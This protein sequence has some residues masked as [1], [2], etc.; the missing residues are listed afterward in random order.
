MKHFLTILMMII[1]MLNSSSEGQSIWTKD[2]ANPVLT[3]IRSTWN[4]NVELPSVLYNSDSARYEMWFCGDQGIMGQYYWRPYHIGYAV[5]DDG[6]HWDMHDTP[7]LDITA[8]KWDDL[9]VE[10]PTVIHEN[11]LYKMWYSGWNMADDSIGIGYATSADGMTWTKHPSY[12]FGPG[13]ADWESGYPYSCSVM[14][15][16]GGYEMWYSATDITQSEFNIGYATSS[17]GIIWQRDTVNNP[18]LKVGN[19][20]CWDDYS[21]I[22][23]SVHLID[24]LYCLWYVGINNAGSKKGGFACSNDGIDWRKFNDPATNSA[25]YAESDPV[26]LPSFGQWDG[27]QVE[28]GGMLMLND[29]LH[30]WYTGWTSPAPPNQ[31]QIGHAFMSRGKL[32]SLIILDIEENDNSYFP[33]GYSLSQNFPNPFNPKTMINYQLPITNYV[34]LSVHNLLGQKVSTIVSKKQSAGRHQVEFDAQNLS[35]GIYFY[36]IEAGNF[37]ETRKMIYLK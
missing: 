31:V 17:D 12:I 32:D 4:Q 22:V 35:S 18:V 24:N 26:L 36:R 34:E 19:P 15:V 27:S 7:V 30:M 25:A 37:S 29:T 10:A 1:I 9:T 3:G 2:P 33:K 14:P 13:T 6:I 20:G 21:V 23:S 28:S 8:G 5:S 16:T 11:G